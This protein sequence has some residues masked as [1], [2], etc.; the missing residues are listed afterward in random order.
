VA[1]AK[2]V[3][4]SVIYIDDV[5]IF[6]IAKLVGIPRLGLADLELPPETAQGNLPFD[7]V[8]DSTDEIAVQAE[9]LKEPE[10]P[11]DQPTIG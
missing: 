10:I 7:T 6:A 5:D 8:K 11:D 2:T 4:A 9:I 1:I 3:Q